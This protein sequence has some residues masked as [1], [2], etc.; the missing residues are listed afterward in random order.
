MN[1]QA[2]SSV[3][4]E[5]TS[6]VVGSYTSTPRIVTTSFCLPDKY[7]DGGWSGGTIDRPA[8]KRLLA[9]IEAGKVDCVVVY[10]VDRLSRSLMDF[11]RMMQVFDKHHVSLVSATQAF[12]DT[13]FWKTFVQ[14]RLI[15][16]IGDPGCLSLFGGGVSEST[17]HRLLAE[18]L[19]AEYRERTQGRG[20]ELDEWKLL[21][22]RVDNHW[23]DCL[24]GC[25]VAGS[26][27]GAVLF[28][29]DQKRSKRTRLRLSELQKTRRHW[30]AKPPWQRRGE[31]ENL[32]SRGGRS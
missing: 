2:M 13:N 8:L 16:P 9:D 7:D 17:D 31:D 4:F 28:G 6:P 1:Q 12:I 23:L 11:A 29:T 24:V 30:K 18:H 3:V 10:K 32:E 27:A 19:T 14:A 26:M 20:R 25:A 15:V 5:R 22:S 21:P